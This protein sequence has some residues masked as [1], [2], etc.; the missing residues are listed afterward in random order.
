MAENFQMSFKV[1]KN[2]IKYIFLKKTFLKI[3]PPSY[4]VSKTQLINLLAINAI[5][6]PVSWPQFNLECLM[7]RIN[8]LPTLPVHSWPSGIFSQKKFLDKKATFKPLFHY[9]KNY[10]RRNNFV[11]I[12]S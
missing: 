2:K 9:K 4:S 8:S 1:N 3:D 6:K 12:L 10:C 5:L 11:L 7:N